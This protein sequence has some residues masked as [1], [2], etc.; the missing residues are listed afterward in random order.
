MNLLKLLPTSLKLWLLK[1]LYTDI[2][3]KG[4][5]GDT[6]LA[7]INTEE[8]A[9]LKAQGG[10]GTVNPATGLFEYGK[11]GGGAPPPQQNTSTQSDLPE[12]A[13]PFYEELMKQAGKQTYTTD[14]AG[15]VTGVQEKPAYGGD[16]L[17]G[18]TEDQ[19]N[20]QAGIRGLGA[21]PEFEEAITE[22][23]T[24]G[25]LGAG[26]AASG[27]GAASAFTPGAVADIGMATPAEF[28][29]AAASRYMSPY[30]SNVTD[31]Q[32]AEARRQA[33]IA[34]SGR[35]MGSINRGTFGG[36]R[37]ALMEGEAD[38]NLAMQLGQIQATGSQDAYKN[39]QAQFQADQ[40]RQMQASQANLQADVAGRQLTQQGEQFG[41]GLQKDLGLAGMQMGLG[42]AAQKG[43]LSS[44]DQVSQLQ[45]LQSQAASG[46]EQQALQQE[47]DN[48]AYQE[49]MEA[50]D[51][52]KKQLEYQSNILRG[53]A[54]ALGSTQTQYTPAPSLAGQ[55][56]S[57]GLAGLGLYNALK[58]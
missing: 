34:K 48:L 56:T 35:G 16:R 58:G 23:E 12:Y 44:S 49:F 25:G 7:H 20:V 42:A 53:T 21:R 22:T 6:T 43:T 45:L 33:D 38:R 27:L 54:G 11:G 14:S 19:T 37:Q 13:Q 10:S 46:A 26:V 32:L 28:D 30:Q 50:Q 15:N 31:I 9:L 29:G 52:Q 18:F 51:Y 1:H 17:A 2:A 4:R 47:I 57:G 3:A 39:A 36:G 8:A 55:I 41:A 24:I 5:M 40:A